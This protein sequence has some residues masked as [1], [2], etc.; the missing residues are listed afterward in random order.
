MDTPGKIYTYQTGHF[1]VTSRKGITYVFVL[2]CYDVYAIIT[3][4]LKDRKVKEST[5]SYKN[6]HKEQANRGFKTA[7]HWLDNQAS[8]ALK[9]SDRQQPVAFQFVPPHTHRRNL[10]E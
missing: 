5:R 7:T 9:T 3:E 1:P 8:E 2:Y 6:V 10:S 4:T